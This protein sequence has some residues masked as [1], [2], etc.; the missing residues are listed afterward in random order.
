MRFIVAMFVFP[1]VMVVF[2][3]LGVALNAAV[4]PVYREALAS[5]AGPSATL[6]RVLLPD[7]LLE[8]L[9]RFVFPMLAAVASSFGAL[10]FST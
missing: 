8:I 4:Q 2:L 1:I 5:M 3:H 7:F 10:K 9:L 6:L